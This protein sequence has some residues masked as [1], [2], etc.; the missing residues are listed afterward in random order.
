MPLDLSQLSAQQS[1]SKQLDPA[2]LFRTLPVNREKFK[3]LRDVQAEVIKRWYDR[4]NDRD[5]RIKMNTGGGKTLV[6]MLLLKSCLNEGFGP[7][8]YI[9]PTP[10]L[11][12]Q[13]AAEANELGIAVSKDPR[14][15]TVASGREVLVTHIHVLL[16][17]MS[18]FGVGNEAKIPIGSIVIDDAHSCLNTAEEQFTLKIERSS[19]LFDQI[20]ALFSHNLE[21][22]SSIAAI[23]IK[24]GNGDVCLRVPYW[25]WREQLSKVTEILYAEKNDQLRFS[26]PLLS[27]VLAE[28]RCVVSSSRI[29]ITPRCLPIAVI[30]SFGQAKR[31][32]FMSATFA[33][34][35]VLITDFAAAPELIRHAIAPANASDI[36][37]RLILV[38]QELNP[39]LSDEELRRLAADYS[40]SINVVV[41]VPSDHR[42]K[43]WQ[44]HSQLVLR[45]DT[46]EEG[47]SRLRQEHV[48][49]TVIVNK[50]D[51]ID[52]PN[53]ACRLLI[54]DDLPDVQSLADR[55]DESALTG[56][57]IHMHR[58]IQQIEQG[59]GRGVR[60]A[61][62]FCAV[63]L[64]GRKLTARLYANGA[65]QGFSPATLAQF[66]LSR[67]LGEQIRNKGIDELRMAIDTCL[68]RDPQWTQ[69]SR[70]SLA[71]VTYGE[72][73]SDTS[74]AIARR[75]A[76]DKALARDHHGAAQ[77]IE[78]AVNTETDP[79]VKGWL[80]SE[81]AEY[82]AN[83]DPS[84]SQELALKAHTLN[85]QVM[86][87]IAG[88]SYQK[89]SNKSSVQSGDLI[90]FLRTRFLDGNQM[91]VHANAML[92]DL[93]FE[94]VS[95]KRFESAFAEIGRFLGFNAQRP[96]SEYGSGPDVLWAIGSLQYFV[97][98][99]KNEAS[100]EFISKDYV[101]QLSGS[102]HWFSEN[103]DTT[104][105][106]VPVLV[107]PSTRI[108]TAASPHADMRVIDRESLSKLKTSFVSF[109]KGLATWKDFGDPQKVTDHLRACSFDTASFLTSYTKTVTRG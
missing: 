99:C 5:L 30:P 1:N 26:W 48:G 40:R 102:I 27:D 55:V 59:M 97:V 28:C 92:E 61:E 69:I 6:G 72:D 12:D 16:N 109:V 25:A 31:R 93:Q 77:S 100:T 51:G 11:A 18:K 98:E 36:G 2:T 14:A 107:H 73:N 37:E 17:G 20:V 68:N 7:A 10:Y 4:R 79:K 88:V 52:L 29:E 9:A 86:R 3:Y 63:L 15:L 70:N 38:P 108:D 23:E 101:N 33:D 75:E 95:F 71:S 57:R 81:Y 103:Y 74:L 66:E 64:M 49:L 91:L 22:Q 84:Y 87:P 67:S 53:D 42:L 21:E 96:E 45:A 24:K 44:Q 13:V 106:V 83:Y 54:I 60:S 78:R 76:F 43:K 47:V 50:F 19:S 62:D 32:I 58:G 104:C 46:L 90:S 105:K 89:L 85:T 41:I 82:V 8:V 80:M 39:D 34:D 35:N 94:S 65:I 56:T